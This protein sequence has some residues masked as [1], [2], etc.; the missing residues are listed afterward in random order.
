MTFLERILQNL[1]ATPAKSILIEVHG[2]E[3]RPTTCGELL[4]DIGRVRAALRAAGVGSGDRVALLG[5]NSARWVA[6]DL[7]IMAEDAIV[8]PLYSRQAPDELVAMLKDCTPRLLLCANAELRDAITTR[9][10]EA[11]RTL[12]Y[13][14]LFEDARRAGGV[15]PPSA[16]D[17]PRTDAPLGGL[18]PPARQAAAIIYTSGTS[19]EAKGVVLTHDNLRFMVEY[20]SRRVLDLVPDSP[21]EAEHRVFHYLPYCFAGSWIMLLTCLYRN[22][23]IMMSMDLTKLMDEVQVAAPHYFLS[24]PALLERVRNGVYTKLRAKG[25]IGA[26]IFFRADLSLRARSLSFLDKLT[27]ALARLLIFPKIRAKLGPHLR[28]LVCG[29]APLSEETQRFFEMLCIPVL[30]IYGLTETTAICTM[31]DPGLVTP[32]RVGRAIDGIEMKLGEHEEILVRGPNVFPGYWNRPQATAELIR[33]GWLHTGDQG[34]VDES[35]NWKIVGRIKNLIITSGGHNISPE[36]I[37]ELLQNALPEAEHVMV[38]G[39]DRK[40]LAAL[41]T[42]K[43]SSERVE[44]ALAEVNRDL[45]H[46]KQVRK[47]IC[48][49]PFTT[50]NGLLTANRKLRRA[51]IESRCK[52]ELDRMYQE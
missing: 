4:A 25:G 26:K 15:S 39:N 40:Y 44:A 22:N 8:V 35:G 23:P 47:F 20:T 30:Q 49:E 13:D 37:E 5:A 11:P 31:D 27:V 12:T 42:G 48:V 41:L 43:A 17:D 51:A 45:P 38:V 3:L 21:T 2:G 10:S 9:W 1:A 46:Y 14:A 33:D 18:T 24:V 16:A 52:A 36:P 32:G 29:S 7:A 50:E 19:G 6:A 34:Q 28:A